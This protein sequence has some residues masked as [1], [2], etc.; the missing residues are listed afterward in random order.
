MPYF[1]IILV[2]LYLI[3]KNKNQVTTTPKV[4]GLNPIVEPPLV[5]P[6]KIVFTPNLPPVP[7]LGNRPDKDEVGNWI[8]YADSLFSCIENYYVDDPLIP[9]D[10]KAGDNLILGWFNLNG[11]IDFAMGYIK[12]TIPKRYLRFDRKFR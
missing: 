10:F 6:S 5:V 9:I 11:D 8:D 3:S 2:L 12:H 4:M 7:A 1:L